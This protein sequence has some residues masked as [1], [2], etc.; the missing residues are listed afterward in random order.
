MATDVMVRTLVD[1]LAER[2]QAQIV[3]GEL[4]PGARVTE[5]SIASQYDV[6]RPT[7]KAAIERV[8]QSGLLRRSANKTASVPELT[9]IEIK[10]IYRTRLFFEWSIV[11]VLAERGIAPAEA[12]GALFDMRRA[13]DDEVLADAVDADVRFHT[14]LVRA[15]G[16]PR[17]TR[18]YETLIGEVRLCM[19]QERTTSEFQPFPN[20]KSHEEILDAINARDV[21]ES[22][23]LIRGHFVDATAR[24]LNDSLDLVGWI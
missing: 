4:A 24:L 12:R 16:S 14:A 21:E 7:A 19:A 1:A 11:K 18:M 22:R 17:T 13:L 6:A 2:L 3:S 23:R 5:Q 10:D 20:L 8:V 15:A 9:A